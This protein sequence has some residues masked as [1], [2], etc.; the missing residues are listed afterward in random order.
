ML[1]LTSEIV[2]FKSTKVHVM[3]ISILKNNKE[4]NFN[5]QIKELKLKIL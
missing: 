1:V 5:I 4:R 2:F 3:M